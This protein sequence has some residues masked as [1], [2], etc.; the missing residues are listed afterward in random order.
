LIMSTT[1]GY[2]SVEY[3]PAQRHLPRACKRQT[4]PAGS[5]FDSP[6]SS[7]SSDA[8][9][10]YHPT[11]AAAEQAEHHRHIRSVDRHLRQ[12]LSEPQPVTHHSTES[13]FGSSDSSIASADPSVVRSDSPAIPDDDFFDPSTATIGQ[14][15]EQYF[16]LLADNHT[17]ETVADKQS[18][19]LHYLEDRQVNLVVQIHQLSYQLALERA[20]Q[21][22]QE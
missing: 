11:A 2:F 10:E 1:P 17:L 8:G 19:R 13:L 9:S 22:Q 4:P 3:P 14:F 18:A 5:I 6:D 7:D 16:T 15:R 21:T 20:H 12:H